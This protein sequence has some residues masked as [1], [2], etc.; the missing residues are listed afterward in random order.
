MSPKS[1]TPHVL[2]RRHPHMNAPLINVPNAATVTIAELPPQLG[3]LLLALGAPP[4]MLACAALGWSIEHGRP[5]ILELLL[6]FRGHFSA[7][8]MTNLLVEAAARGD[9]ECM[10]L[11]LPFADPSEDHFAA[12]RCCAYCGCAQG[13]AMLIPVSEPRALQSMAFRWAT[14]GAEVSGSIECLRLLAPLSNPNALDFEALRHAA[15]SSLPEAFDFL[16]ALFEPSGAI[17]DLFALAAFA[18]AR[19]QPLAAQT[20]FS[21]AEALAI[22]SSAPAEQPRALSR[23]I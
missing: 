13:V 6:R 8:Y 16:L 5:E 10:R 4:D 14:H 20:I 23:R 11:I 18:S 7:D 19:S 17:P 9:P 1:S 22:S 15:E 21:A 12:L 3:D 2:A